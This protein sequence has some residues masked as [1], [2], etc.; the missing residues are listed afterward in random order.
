MLSRADAFI[1]RTMSRV[2]RMVHAL[3]PR[4]KIYS[5]LLAGLL[6]Y[7]SFIALDHLVIRGFVQDVTGG[8]PLDLDFY[9]NRTSQILNGSIPYKD[10]ASESPPLIMYLMLPPQMAGGSLLA[11]QTYFSAWAVLGGL[12]L[13]LGLRRFDDDKAF[14]VGFV[15]MAMPYSVLEFALGAQDD[16]IS[17]FMFF[18][19]LVLVLCGRM[20][21]AA[22]GGALGF[23]TKLFNGLVF[24]WIILSEEDRKKRNTF[25][26][27]L[28]VIGVA[29]AVPF[30]IICPEKFIEFPA[31][32][33]FQDKNAQTGGSG[34]S[35][36]HFLDL[37]G[38]TLPGIIG[39]GMTLG[40]IIGSTYLAW[41]WKLTP[42]QGFAFIIFAFFIFYPKIAF[43]YFVMMVGLLLPWAVEDRKIMTRLM[44][45]ALPLFLAVPFSENGLKPVF[46]Y[47]WGWIAGLA[48]SLVAWY[49]LFTTFRMTWKKKCFIDA[50]K[51][52]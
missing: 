19:P 52:P 4:K 6:I 31:Y 32:Y 45:M 40:A 13:Y 47:S 16:A 30:L 34:Q 42:W 51:N 15:Y 43:V 2:D 44:V 12:M 7:G 35:P 11:Y 38:F 25:I 3:P 46:D 20:V 27:A 21:G 8:D 48:L 49:I 1:T 18:L 23:W 33:F 28:L 39:V 10:F 36:W 29:V 50:K 17:F 26:L 24:P 41:R 22:A 5:L 14:M 9:R 37:G